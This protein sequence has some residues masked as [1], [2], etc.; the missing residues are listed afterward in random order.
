MSNNELLQPDLVHLVKAL[1]GACAVLLPDAPTFSVAALTEDYLKTGMLPGENVLHR[2]L[3]EVYSHHGPALVQQLTASLEEV[4]QNKKEHCFLHKLSDDQ[5][6]RF[7]QKPVPGMSGELTYILHIINV[8]EK[9]E[10]DVSERNARLNEQIYFTER[11]NEAI[12]DILYSMH[13]NSRKVT[14]INHPFERKM[15]YAT[16]EIRQMDDPLFTIM[17]PDDIPAVLKHI[18]DMRSVKD[19]E[20][21]EVEYRLRHVNG[22]LHWFRDRDTVFKRDEQGNVLEKIGIAQDITV[23]K[24]AEQALQESN[25][26][27]QYANERLQQFAS[28]ASHDLQEPLRKIKLY[29]SRLVQRF[30]ND[31]PEE[32]KD[33]VGKIKNAADRMS[34]LIADVLQYSKIAYS[35]K[36]FQPTPL[37]LILTQ[38]LE[39]LNEVVEK[40][41][42]Q[43]QQLASL[44]TIDAVPIQMRHLFYNI[45]SNAIK[46]KANDKAP[47]IMI[48]SR[49]LSA[50][51]VTHYSQL[52]PNFTYAEIVI[53]DNGFGFEQQYALQIFQLFERLHTAEEFEGTG[54]GL[55]LCKK[56]VENHYG[57]IFARSEEGKGA[58]F[59]II[60]PLTQ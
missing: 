28:I 8:V 22:S 53:Q 30:T 52:R 14:Y 38:V 47:V 27:L 2:G 32:G 24:A 49:M 39:E 21:L 5:V 23:H 7:C 18:E 1:P 60:L 45:L 58:S 31:L 40:T 25:L 48:D 33:V 15:G 44:P 35:E 34:Q 9:T 43:V 20:F 10:Q 29:S 36:A 13:L 12:T 54:I 42:T 16:E 11:T 41:G 56:V 59:H 46:Y 6:L 55:A 57:H 37:D 4:I 3:L 19:G 50:N 17:Y 26:N 51:E